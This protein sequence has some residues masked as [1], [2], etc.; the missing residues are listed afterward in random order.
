NVD[1][2]LL[3]QDEALLKSFDSQMK[4]FYRALR[5][6]F[7]VYDQL[8][9]DASRYAQV[10]AHSVGTGR[11]SG[12]PTVGDMAETLAAKAVID[13]LNGR[14]RAFYDDGREARADWSNGKVGM[15]GTSYDGTLP[16]MVATTGVEGL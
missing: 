6:S 14:A 5:K 11:S 8:S 10:R 9:V 13:W 16:I 12:C 15:T 3:P 1:S 7:V 4:S 2:N